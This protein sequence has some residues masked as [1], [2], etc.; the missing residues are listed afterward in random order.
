[1]MASPGIVATCGATSRR[2]RP[3]ETMR[4]HDGVGGWT[5][6]PRKDSAASTRMAFA[7]KRVE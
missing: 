5:P 3:V 7:M 4:P 6:S 1:M 2:S